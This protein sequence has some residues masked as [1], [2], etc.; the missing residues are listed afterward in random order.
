M[1]RTLLAIAAVAATAG[2]PGPY[3]AQHGGAGSE[4]TNASGIF[5]GTGFVA[6]SALVDY[7]LGA[8]CCPKSTVGQVNVY[9]FERAG[10]SCATLEGA[11]DK[12]FFS[13]TVETDGKSLAVGRIAPASLFQQASFNVIGNTT[14]FQPGVSILFTR[15]D[16]AGGG[17]WHGRITV[18]SQKYNGKTYSLNGTFAA[19]WC[20]TKRS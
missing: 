13:Y 2:A 17:I 11:K 3:P 16:T 7:E 18:P 9:L 8:S 20:G 6:R 12:R 5:A 15:I 14:G 4:P 19:R 10:V 1:V